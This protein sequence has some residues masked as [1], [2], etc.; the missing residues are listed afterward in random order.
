MINNPRLNES[1][2]QECLILNKEQ[3]DERSVATGDAMKN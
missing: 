3:N 2:G 1:V